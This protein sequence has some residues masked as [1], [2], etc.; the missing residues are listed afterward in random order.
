MVIQFQL[1]AVSVVLRSQTTF[2]RKEKVWYNA[3]VGLVQNPPE[4][5]DQ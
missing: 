1:V 3:Y 5:G 4:L 2:A